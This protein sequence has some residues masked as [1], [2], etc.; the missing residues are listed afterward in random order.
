MMH[1]ID[2]TTTIEYSL[3][4]DEYLTKD[5]ILKKKKKG[6]WLKLPLSGPILKAS[7]VYIYLYMYMYVCL[8]LD[9]SIF[10]LYI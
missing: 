8:F 3:E 10:D 1:E 7:C 4:R 6:Q 5:H 2:T 9:I